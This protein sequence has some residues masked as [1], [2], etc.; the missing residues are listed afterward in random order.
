MDAIEEIAS[1][2]GISMYEVVKNAESHTALGKTAEKL[3]AFSAIIESVRVEKETPSEI[4][5]ALYE[6]SGYEA[7]LRS[8]GFEGEGKMENIEEFIS[9]AVEYE[10]R[11]ADS[12]ES[13]TCHGFLE[14]ISLVA[15]VDKY[16]ETADAVV[17]MTVHA[18]KGLEFPVVF[19]AGME[20]G[21]FPSIQNI[22]EAE[23]MSEERRLA[24][25]AITRAK[26]MLYITH[27]RER[28]MYGKTTYNQLSRFIKDEL[29]K[30][31]VFE[32]APRRKP[33]GFGA[34]QQTRPIEN[35][36]SYFNELRR[37]VD[38]TPKKREKEGAAEYGI[39][40]F[41]PGTRVRHDMFGTGEV[42]SA[43]DMGGDVLSEVRFDNGQT[44]K[45]MAT[46]A[47]LK[48]E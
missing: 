26:E 36:Q 37:P 34:Y 2:L 18:A 29:P 43:R 20:D 15:D 9:A 12:G 8:E 16:D 46:F 17:L 5:R 38:M 6:K 47:K 48:K 24:Y 23:E 41:A 3:T 14:E 32:D 25:V 11:C 21:I 40:K 27:A 22:G 35:R 39:T 42:I 19:L 13:A 10:T 30:N 4:I 1:T 28:M 45:L 7:M 31:L 33:Q 44:K